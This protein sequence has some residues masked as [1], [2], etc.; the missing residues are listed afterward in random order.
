ME[1]DCS[2]LR[3]KC[4][5]IPFIG[6]EALSSSFL[7][8]KWHVNCLLS[9]WAFVEDNKSYGEWMMKFSMK[10][11]SM[12][13]LG[14]LLS[15]SVA[16]ADMDV[17]SKNVDVAPVVDG[18]I[19]ASWADIKPLSIVDAAS[20]A[21]ILLRSVYT[22]DRVY[23]LVQFPDSVNN[24]LHKPW[25]WNATSNAYETG[26]HREDTFVFKWNMMDHD[27]D[28]SAFSEDDYTA[29][30]W[31]WKANR[32]NPAGYADDKRQILGSQAMKKSKE[33]QS[34]SGKP[35][36]LARYSDAGKAPYNELKS[37]TEYQGNL[38]DRYPVGK[39]EG[40][41]ADVQAKG[42]WNAGFWTIEF[43]R[44]LDT[45]HEDDVRLEPAREQGH[46]FGV[47][48]FS[49]YGKPHDPN[50]PNYYGRGRISEPLRLKFM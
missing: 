22:E 4:K 1:M 7:D 48:I 46:L 15:V 47:S 12:L 30:V 9:Y 35:R 36:H 41:R 23:F 14:G 13:C 5:K 29:D 45:G 24:F 10:I 50:S 40:S 11:V 17:P 8:E 43:S 2:F 27:V 49:L 42:V 38:V 25:L 34:A 44:K 20:K 18:Q 3:F 19:D 6:S 37:L 26:A 39:P 33:L 31:Y 28:L 21:R 16:V 32:T